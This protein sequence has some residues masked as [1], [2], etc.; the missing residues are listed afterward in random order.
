M[1]RAM[2][3]IALHDKVKR[4]VTGLTSKTKVNDMKRFNGQN[5]VEQGMQQ[6]EAITGGQGD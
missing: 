1:K 4:S 3:H 2:L 6:E 5:E